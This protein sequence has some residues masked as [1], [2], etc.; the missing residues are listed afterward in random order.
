[1]N[2]P[3]RESLSPIVYYFCD[4]NELEMILQ[5]NSF[6]LMSSLGTEAD[7]NA[8]TS[9]YH[10]FMSTARIYYGGY[11]RRN[12]RNGSAI[13]TLDGTKFNH[14]YKSVPFDYWGP[15]YRN[16]SLKMND[17]EGFLKS[18]ENEDRI[19]SNEARIPNA[20]SYIKEITLYAAED[21]HTPENQRSNP[22]TEEGR[23]QI[24]YKNTY[25]DRFIRIAKYC[26]LK[27]IP[28]AIYVTERDFVT[29]NRK[30]A[31]ILRDQG[32]N[33]IKELSLFLLKK[34]PKDEDGEIPYSK[35]PFL[36]D[37]MNSYSQYSAEDY[38][39]SLSVD[40]HNNRANPDYQEYL[41]IIVRFMKK[42]K[43]KTLKDLILKVREEYQNR[44]L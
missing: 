11:V 12:I 21:I 8:D 25:Y 9:G 29:R 31:I 6:L 2:K 5:T 26:Q 44:K 37:A 34:L 28:C 18:D 33:R 14:N 38:A 36:Y 41:E 1:M 23:Y 20:L 24:L 35:Y 7:T 32:P 4:L 15:A 42:Y 43:V 22:D 3:I 39:K 17:M 40:I 13:L 30:R 10:F 27:N 16:T 19:L